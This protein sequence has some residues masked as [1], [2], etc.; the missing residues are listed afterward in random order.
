MV[1]NPSR[2]DLTSANLLGASLERANLSGADLLGAKLDKAQLNQADLTTILHLTQ[3]QLNTACVNKF[4]KLPSSLA[5][6]G[7]CPP[8]PR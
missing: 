5:R 4:T 1:T 3:A 8:D 7:P 6:P 2:I